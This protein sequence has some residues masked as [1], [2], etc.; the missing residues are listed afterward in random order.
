MPARLKLRTIDPDADRCP[1]VGAIKAIVTESRL[2]VVRHLL[3]GPK[4]FN[5]LLRASGINSKT[6]SAT[7]KFLEERRIVRR[8]VLSTRPF[9]VEYS[10][11]PSG[12]E[13]KPVLEG[14]G[15]WGSKWLPESKA[16]VQPVVRKLQGERPIHS[17]F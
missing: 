2:L 15:N 4:G 1:A 16:T 12:Q 9:T 13:L 10:L 8:E 17:S 11:T 3:T 7:L 14:L 5:E 6:L